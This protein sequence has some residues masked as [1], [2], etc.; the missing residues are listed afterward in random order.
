MVRDHVEYALPLWPASIPV[1][2]LIVRRDLE[3]IFNFRAQRLTELRGRRTFL[4]ILRMNPIT[5]D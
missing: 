5:K 4:T 1:H 3:R 2:R